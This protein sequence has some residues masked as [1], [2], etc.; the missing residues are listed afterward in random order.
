MYVVR[1]YSTVLYDRFLAFAFISTDDIIPVMLAFSLLLFSSP[2][3][4]CCVR[5]FLLFSLSHF[6][7]DPT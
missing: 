3:A 5:C 7:V 1:Q 4:A 2:T 6:S